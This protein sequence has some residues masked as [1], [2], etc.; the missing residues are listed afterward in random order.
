[1][2]IRSKNAVMG[3]LWLVGCF[4]SF[5]CTFKV[6]MMFVD[7]TILA[8]VEAVFALTWSLTLPDVG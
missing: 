5:Q 4:E 1:M 2:G 3:L 6:L 7:L 8:N